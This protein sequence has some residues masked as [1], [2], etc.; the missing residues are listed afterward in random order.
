ME[1]KIIYCRVLLWGWGY[2]TTDAVGPFSI[3][4]DLSKLVRMYV[5]MFKLICFTHA[6]TYTQTNRFKQAHKIFQK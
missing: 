3:F 5:Y 2:V 1:I 4:P 6:Y